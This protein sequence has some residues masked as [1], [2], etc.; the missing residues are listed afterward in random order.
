MTLSNM[1]FNF[2][3]SKRVHQ[4]AEMLLKFWLKNIRLG[5]AFAIS[6]DLPKTL[7]WIQ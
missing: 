2:N 4:T 7:F 1:N 6:D 3:P 5:H